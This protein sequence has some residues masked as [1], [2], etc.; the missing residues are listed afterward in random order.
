MVFPHLVDFHFAQ[1][2]GPNDFSP[3]FKETPG[4]RNAHHFVVYWSSVLSEIGY[5]ILFRWAPEILRW[6]KHLTSVWSV[7]IRV[8][9]SYLLHEVRKETNFC[10]RSRGQGSL[11]KRRCF[12]KNE[13]FLNIDLLFIRWLTSECCEACKLMGIQLLKFFNIWCSWEWN[14]RLGTDLSAAVLQ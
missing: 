1:I 6:K 2:I 3:E 11:C 10:K 4:L 7:L 13:Q 14:Q 8:R 9:L 12:L 5:W